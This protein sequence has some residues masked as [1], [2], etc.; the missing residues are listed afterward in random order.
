VSD[1]FNTIIHSVKS[2][3]LGPASKPACRSL[4]V[5]LRTSLANRKQLAH[6]P[7][8]E[9]PATSSALRST[10]RQ[11]SRGHSPMRALNKRWVLA[12]RVSNRVFAVGLDKDMVG[13]GS[14]VD[15]AA[16]LTTSLL[17]GRSAR[18]TCG[19]RLQVQ[20]RDASDQVLDHQHEFKRDPACISVLR[21]RRS[22]PDPP[23]LRVLA[24]S[25]DGEISPRRSRSSSRPVRGLLRARF[26]DE[27]DIVAS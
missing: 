9:S 1:T 4:R 11:A 24:L 13:F 7:D 21:P 19:N 23:E 15:K 25:P 8:K 12:F 3:P 6:R 22:F 17:I 10:L 27:C 14:I 5:P 2:M 16:S 20:C 26:P 18:R